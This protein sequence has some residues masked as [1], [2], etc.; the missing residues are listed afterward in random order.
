MV[1]DHLPGI[2]HRG[3]VVGLIPLDQQLEKIEQQVKLA[4]ANLKFLS[5]REKLNAPD[6]RRTQRVVGCR[7]GHEKAGLAN[8][9]GHLATQQ[10]GGYQPE[11][12]AVAACIGIIA[13]QLNAGLFNAGNPL[14]DQLRRVLW[15]AGNDQVARSGRD[16]AVSPG[17]DQQ[18]VPLQ[19]GGL[20]TDVDHPVP[21]S[22]TDH[23]Q[24]HFPGGSQ[25]PGK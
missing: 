14:G 8:D 13:R 25:P 17:V 5:L 18:E 3:E 15:M 9:A 20:H 7:M 21:R 6:K 4:L 1:A 22:Q 24:K 11:M 23:P 19:D 12:S 10:R 16:V 2:S